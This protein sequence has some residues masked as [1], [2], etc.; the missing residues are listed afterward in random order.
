MYVSIV[1]RSWSHVVLNWTS[2][3]YGGTVDFADLYRLIIWSYKD[4]IAIT[5]N[6][7]HARIDGLKQ[8][9]NYLLN[10]QA[11]NKLGFGPFL[12]NNIS[13]RTPGK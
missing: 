13:F 9:T 7:T 5:S 4:K 12:S 1:S 11:W 6:E 8:L 2:P 3:F 10:V